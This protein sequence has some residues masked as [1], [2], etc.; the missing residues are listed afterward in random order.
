MLIIKNI[1]KSKQNSNNKKKLG[2]YKIDFEGLSLR[3]GLMP[4][5]Q[6]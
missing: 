6:E 1:E 3:S 2:S 5:S 4:L